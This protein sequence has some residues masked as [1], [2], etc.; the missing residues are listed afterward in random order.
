MSDQAERLRSRLK[1][2]HGTKKARTVAVSSGKG[3]VGKSNFT[4][5]FALKLLQQDKKVLIIDMDIGMGNI[6]ILLGV[7]PKYSFVDL[8]HHGHSIHDI[9]ESGPE[10]LSYIAGGSGLSDVFQLD[11]AKFKHFQSQFESIL[12]SFDFILFDMG[13]GATNDS[14]NFISAADEAFV[15][16][17]PEPTSITDAYAMIKH[18]VRID[19][20]LP[21][22]ILVNRSLKEKSDSSFK[23]LETVVD[24]FLMKQVTSLGVIPDDRSVLKSVNR[25][26]PFVLAHPTCK[27]SRA[28]TDVV[29]HYLS[30]YEVEPTF[31]EVPSFL[32]KL[33][34]F[35][36]E[37][38]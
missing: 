7:S 11:Q 31:E 12:T 4:I 10:N 14:L 6:D 32:S 3:G 29:D 38:S 5:N 2:K 21:I 20:Q 18:L 27:A 15:V 9:I 30:D 19:E 13:A 36:F 16:T 25:Q 34:R 26:Q 17:T 24:R 33:K 37:R 1:E 22:S 23:R 35:V 8:F 28:M